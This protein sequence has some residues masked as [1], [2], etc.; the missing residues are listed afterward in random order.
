M[1]ERGA[2]QQAQAVQDTED[3]PGLLSGIGAGFAELFARERLQV[4][5]NGSYQASSR[6]YETETSLRTY[7]EQARLSTREEFGGGGHVDVGG[8]LRVWRG[9]VLGASFTQV[10]DSG[11]AEVTGTVPHPIVAERDRTIPPQTPSLARRER[12]THAY[13]AWRISLRSLEVELSAGPSYFSLRQ[14]V[15]VNLTPTEVVGPPFAEVGLHV[16]LGEHTRSGVGYNAGI[17][18]TYMFTAATRIPQVG[19]GYF[20]RVT[21]GTV[22]LPITA[23]TRRRVAV[24]GVQTGAGL[25]LRF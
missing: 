2:R 10:R 11:S 22:S 9:L 12:G 25:R 15:V 7:G 14:G 8:S 20:V 24:G 5:V 18:V 19:I 1:Q 23:D 21:G 3:R 17:D 13:L 6:Q 16:D 4:Y